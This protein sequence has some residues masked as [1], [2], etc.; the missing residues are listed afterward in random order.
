LRSGELPIGLDRGIPAFDHLPLQLGT[1]ERRDFDS[2]ERGGDGVVVEGIAG[3]GQVE[4]PAG[5][6]TGALVSAAQ[7][8]IAALRHERCKAGRYGLGEKRQP[9]GLTLQNDPL[10]ALAFDDDLRGPGRRQ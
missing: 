5:L 2:E 6:E 7:V 1:V 10:K 8:R 9:L 4:F 3:L